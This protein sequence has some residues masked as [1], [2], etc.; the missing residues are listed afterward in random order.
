MTRRRP[1]R[2]SW[3]GTLPPVAEAARPAVPADALT[4]QLHEALEVAFPAGVPD[5][6]AVLLR[7]RGPRADHGFPHHRTTGKEQANG[8]DHA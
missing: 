5:H 6:I 8:T 7:P 1:R 3:S 2:T 4:P